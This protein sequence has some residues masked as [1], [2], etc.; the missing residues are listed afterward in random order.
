[1]KTVTSTHTEL[2]PG[3]GFTPRQLLDGLPVN[4][5]QYE[6]EGISTCVLEGGA[7]RPLVLLH[8]PG[9]FALVWLRV[10]PEF[11]KTHRVI[12]PD[13]PGHG[14]S[15]M[16]TEPLNQDRT[17]AWLDAL[18]GATC[19][20][21]PILAGHLLGGSI[22]I[23]YALTHPH[24]LAGLVPVDT[25]GLTPLR[26]AP[27]FALA[28]VAFMVH[29]TARSRDRLFRHCF[30]DIDRLR[31]EFG[32]LWDPLMAYALKGARNAAQKAAL[33][34]L[35]PP[36]GLRTFSEE[37]LARIDVPVSLIWGRHD[38]QTPLRV[39][40]EAS[41]RYGWP[42]QVIEGAA[43]DPAFERPEEFLRAFQLAMKPHLRQEAVH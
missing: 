28:L 25:F 8:G 20:E 1:M 22:A 21:P 9:E 15:G 38:L 43:D 32:D 17:I 39:A 41:D 29:P 42:L 33:R 30:T 37:E 10:I 27:K 23:R 3:P 14:A 4:E 40:E 35:M 2:S 12:I 5:R 11:A 7:D 16:G 34:A 31:I 19:P 26:P 24:R 36:F 6:L 18:I 13:L